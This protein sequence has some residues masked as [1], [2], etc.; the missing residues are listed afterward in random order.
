MPNQKRGFTLK[1]IKSKP[2]KENASARENVGY[3]EI[4]SQ[5]QIL[6][7]ILQSLKITTK[8]STA[9]LK[10]VIQKNTEFTKTRKDL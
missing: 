1:V 10:R 9:N 7:F 3:V 8:A 4:S 5:L 2:E 6:C